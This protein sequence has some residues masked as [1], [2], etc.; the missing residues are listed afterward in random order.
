MIDLAEV[1]TDWRKILTAQIYGQGQMGG[2]ETKELALGIAQDS[3]WNR[4][5]KLVEQLPWW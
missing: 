1:N 2:S 5:S 3:L 4:I